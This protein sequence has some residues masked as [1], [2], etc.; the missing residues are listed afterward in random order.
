MNK[1]VTAIEF[2]NINT[3]EPITVDKAFSLENESMHFTVAT[4]AKENV[5]SFQNCENNDLNKHKCKLE[6]QLSAIK[7]YINYE[8]SILPNKIKSIS[9]DFEKRINTLQGKKRLI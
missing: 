1:T 3:N 9:N 5:M 6:A 2:S 4:P 7:R 8:V